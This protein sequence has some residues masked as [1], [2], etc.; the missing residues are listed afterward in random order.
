MTYGHMHFK[1]AVDA[2]RF[3]H[4]MSG[5]NYIGPNEG[6]VKF[7]PAKHYGQEWKVHYP[8]VE[9]VLHALSSPPH[10][11]PTMV[12]A[13][14]T[15]STTVTSSDVSGDTTRLNFLYQGYRGYTISNESLDIVGTEILHVYGYDECSTMASKVDKDALNPYLL[16]I[17]IFYMDDLQIP[18]RYQRTMTQLP[19]ASDDRKTS[20][21]GCRQRELNPMARER[22]H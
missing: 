11:A 6:Y 10:I 12:S 2:C 19:S 8:K 4:A 21:H 22:Y 15:I 3:Y 5:R 18:I 20:L 14:G 1:T 7:T 16:P 9:E 17:Y 13:S